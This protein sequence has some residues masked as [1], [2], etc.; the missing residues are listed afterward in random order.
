MP[1]LDVYTDYSQ[2]SFLYVNGVQTGVDI[3]YT[4]THIASDM[5][6]PGP[7]LDLMTLLDHMGT[8]T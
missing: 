8:R 1:S 6:S 2:L 5:L 4:G 7:S 3:A